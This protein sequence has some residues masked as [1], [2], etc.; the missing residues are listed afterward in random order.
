MLTKTKM[1]V[2]AGMVSIGL[3]A[4]SAAVQATTITQVLNVPGGS[5][6]NGNIVNSIPYSLFNS[7]L[8]TL[9]GVTL[10]L[11][12][13]DTVTSEVFNFSGSAQ[14]VT[15][16]SAK[17]PLTIYGPP[18]T[19][20]PPY[21]LTTYLS[22]TTITAGPYT[23]I[24]AE[25]GPDVLGSAS[26]NTDSGVVVV[27]SSD[28][29]ANWETPGGG[30]SSTDL[31]F[32]SGS[33]SYTGNANSGVFFGGVA[34]VSGSFTLIYTYQPNLSFGTPEPGAW[35][36]LMASASVSLAGLRRRRRMTK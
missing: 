11:V 10:E 19:V 25:G 1:K 4:C 15:N 3:L 16:A 7:T 17:F 27:P 2:A 33:G 14:S 20:S 21:D 34:S 13:T 28:W 9:T 35:A 32:A 22:T 12:T 8:G 31:V 18:T 30:S 26:G 36:L 5:N 23:G 29:P 6:N 24:A